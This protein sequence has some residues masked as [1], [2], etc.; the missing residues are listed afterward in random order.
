MSQYKRDWR[1]HIT[2]YTYIGSYHVELTSPLRVWSH[3]HPEP[4]P[5][6]RRPHYSSSSPEMYN[7]RLNQ[8]LSK[9]PHTCIDMDLQRTPVWIIVLPDLA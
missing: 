5:T 8:W 4:E 9:L 6:Q 2:L 3:S 1:S 7:N